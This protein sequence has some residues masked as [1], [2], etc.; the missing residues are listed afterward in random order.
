MHLQLN[1]AKAKGTAQVRGNAVM[2]LDLHFTANV[3]QLSKPEW[4]EL[5]KNFD[6]AN[7]Y[8]TSSFGAVRWG[9][10]N[11]SHL[12]LYRNG[13]VVACAQLIVLRMPLTN[14]GVAYL[15]WGPLYRLKGNAEDLHV[16]RNMIMALHEEY[17][18]RRR[19]LLR[20]IPNIYAADN[21]IDVLR[22]LFA[23]CGFSPRTAAGNYRTFV[24]DLSPSLEE[25]RKHFDQKWRNQLHRA[26]KNGLTVIQGT[27]EDLFDVFAGL[28]RE[29]MT[30]K[31]FKTT[32]DINDFRN[33][34]RELGHGIEMQILVCEYE[35][36][37]VAGAVLSP[38]GDTGIY[39]LG[40]TNTDGMKTKSAYLLQWHVIK[41][42]KKNGYRYYDLG[43]IDQ[44]KNPGVYH[45]KAGMGG[46][47][48]CLV[49]Q[50][51]AYG[52]ITGQLVVKM[53]EK[54]SQLYI[55]TRRAF[56]YLRIKLAHHEDRSF[57]TKERCLI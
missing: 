38:L 14:V 54:M 31:Q 27:G 16:F 21:Q 47:N 23:D 7:I 42:L 46:R 6:D 48:L 20:I 5:L 55:N 35:R 51:E 9:N 44:Q 2:G 17:V 28:Y 33:I 41:W 13:R 22:N 34:Q 36:K 30:R 45:F 52:C 1:S 12:K 3:S 15:R 32:I 43:G 53:V 37:P 26:E 11:L 56:Q 49:E 39:L 40:A 29:M 8:Q 10:R 18:V 50:Y 57:G 19:L 24:L 25:L 4:S